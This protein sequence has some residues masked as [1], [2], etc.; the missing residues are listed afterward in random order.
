MQEFLL[1]ATGTFA[2][3]KNL[4]LRQEQFPLSTGG[5]I[6]ILCEEDQRDGRGKLVVVELKRR[7]D[8]GTTAQVVRYLRDLAREPVATDR[9]GVRAIVISG[10]DD[11]PGSISHPES[12]MW[13]SRGDG[14]ESAS[15]T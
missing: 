3:L 11:P 13:I 2:P 1:G 6:D 10:G 12:K 7:S 15:M 9:P 5:R 8:E 4:L 14:S